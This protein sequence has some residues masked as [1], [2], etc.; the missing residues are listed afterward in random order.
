MKCLARRS[1]VSCRG[2]ALVEF[3]LMALVLYLLIAGGI[4]LG[5]MI[6]VSQALQ[7]AARIAA[8]QLALAELPLTEPGG[9]D[10]T[11]LD[12]L[13]DSNVQ[14]NIWDETRLVIDV[15]CHPTDGQ[16][17]DFWQQNMPAVNRALR[18]IFISETVDLGNGPQTLMRYPGALLKLKTP[19]SNP[20]IGTCP[21]ILADYTVGIPRINDTGGMET[22]DWVPILQE[23]PGDAVSMANPQCGSFPPTPLPLDPCIP[24]PT[25]PPKTP[26]GVAAVMVNYPFQSGAL[27]SFRQ[28]PGSAED[29]L[30]PNLGNV[31][32]ADDTTALGEAS[33]PLNPNYTLADPGSAC[34]P[35]TVCGDTV[36]SGPL[37]LGAQYAFAGTKGPNGTVRPYRRLLF[38]QAM[39]HREVVQ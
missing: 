13:A 23:I 34:D 5:R 19:S 38:G 27:S 35:T 29:P 14:A 25:N 4:E 21:S 37:G 11:F 10:F 30:P 22:I 8:R 2:A 20:V 31:N 15:S 24:D 12:A 9:S 6:M 26:R 16:L 33:D 28:T 39:F 18:P 17:E 1:R 36:Y 32:A 3:A 7:D